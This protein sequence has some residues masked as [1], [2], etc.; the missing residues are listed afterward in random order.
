MRFKTDSHP[1]EGRN[2]EDGGVSPNAKDDPE[3]LG[4]LVLLEVILLRQYGAEAAV[5]RD[6]GQTH[7]LGKR[8]NPAE[9]G[10]SHATPIAFFWKRGEGK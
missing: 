9:G 6:H 10:K 7:P 2:E 8:V 4:G 5:Q 3:G 1:R